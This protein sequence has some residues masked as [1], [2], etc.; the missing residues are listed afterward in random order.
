MKVLGVGVE[1][2]AT[3]ATGEDTVFAVRFRD[4]T[5]GQVLDYLVNL[6]EPGLNFSLPPPWDA[7]NSIRLDDFAFEIDT[8]H[9]RIGFRY[10]GLGFTFPLASLDRI[11]VW[12]S[13]PTRDR[14][15]SLDISLFGSFLGIDF[16]SPPGLTWDALSQ[17]APA[18][19]GKGP[20]YFDLEYLGIGQHVALRDPASATTLA[21]VLAAL[22]G[23]YGPVDRRKNPLAGLPALRFDP[24]GGWLVGTKF[25]ALDTVTLAVVF[26]DPSLFGLRIT[27]DGPRAK[28]LAGL[29]FEILYRRINDHLGVYHVELKLPDVLRKIEAGEATITLPVI[30]LDVY[31][32]GDFL[33]DLGFPHNLDFSRSFSVD[34]I[35][36][37]GPIPVPVSAAGGLYF[38][39]LSG[40]SST[41]VPAI[42]NGRFAPVIVAGFGVRVGL[43]KSLAIG[44]LDA[45]FFAG[46]VG[47]LEGVLAWFHPDDPA[48]APATYFKVRGTV[49][50]QIHI[51]GRIDFSILQ[52]S[53]DIL[54]Y[55]TASVAI[56]SHQPIE[57]GFSAG[58]SLE[59]S[60]KVLF[61]HIT[62]KFS[63]TITESFTIGQ[64]TP[65]PW[66]VDTSAPAPAAVPAAP[67]AERGL[68]LA[69]GRPVAAQAAFVRL[70][71]AGVEW[72]DQPQLVAAVT[73]PSRTLPL[74]V[75]PMVTAARPDDRPGGS[76]TAAPQPHLVAMLFVADRGQLEGALA[77]ANRDAKLT[78][79]R[80]VEL[81]D[82]SIRTTGDADTS[83]EPRGRRRR[84]GPRQCRV[85]PRLAQPCPS[86]LCSP[87]RTPSRS[88]S[89]RP[90][91]SCPPATPW[92]FATTPSR[93]RIS[94]E[95]SSHPSSSWRA[96]CCCGRSSP[97]T[98]GSPPVRRSRCAPTAR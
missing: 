63:A 70:L 79:G 7:L 8:T 23:S 78:P 75:H 19:P 48:I 82:K 9:F 10:D 87:R 34:L 88:R 76:G 13:P 56:E 60:V 66:Q 24:T 72:H 17:P 74:Y 61:F 49:G 2:T 40:E 6:A 26:D 37:V 96:T 97:P 68:V 53:V 39:V 30:D 98:P 14:A 38:G 62:L 36:W 95:A 54:A 83:R 69:S 77:V 59:L 86:G 29:A 89:S 20:K 1:A 33:L 43:G 91:D 27:L 3:L 55:A 94:P 31:T 22:E 18:V 58:V 42:T 81:L 45:G 85:H 32:N 11:E 67:Q 46:I 41:Q 21:G 73:A 5:L 52:A 47:I 90:R 51:W 4:L 12:Y 80:Q 71:E 92:C 84:S 64:A 16:T 15:K 28:I 57:V 44:P 93:S 25:S 50:I 65:T 35:V